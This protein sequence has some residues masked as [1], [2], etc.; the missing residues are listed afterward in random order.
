VS[1]K[2]SN[3]S[4]PRVSQHDSTNIGCILLTQPTFFERD[5]WV[6]QPRDWHPRTVTSKGYDL[7]IGEGR[8]IWHACL[9]RTAVR[10]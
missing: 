8:R 7:S 4:A 2:A 9:E 3:E 1:K 6:P 5:A 10:C